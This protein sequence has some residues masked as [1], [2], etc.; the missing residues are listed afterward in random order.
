ML[1]VEEDGG[2]D[3]VG[4]AGQFKAQVLPHRVGI[5]QC[6]LPLEQALFQ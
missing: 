4:L 2:K 6:G 3:L 1:R 5:L